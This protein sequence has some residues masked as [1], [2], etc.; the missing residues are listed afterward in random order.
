VPRRH[1]AHERQIARER[2]VRLGDLSA[3][4]ALAGDLGH[5]DPKHW[6]VHNYII[7]IT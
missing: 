3:T 2:I 4:M 1:K 7:M 5:E 6:S